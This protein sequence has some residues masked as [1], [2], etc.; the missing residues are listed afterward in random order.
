MRDGPANVNAWMKE[1][2][3]HMVPQSKDRVIMNSNY[4]VSHPG[5]SVPKLRAA[6]PGLPDYNSQRGAIRS[7]GRGGG[8]Y[9]NG[10]FEQTASFNFSS[11]R[12][13]QFE[14]KVQQKL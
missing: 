9:N 7:G 6:R 12:H 13:H 14:V 1:G 4:N 10:L 11:R 8:H 3:F 5:R 2:G